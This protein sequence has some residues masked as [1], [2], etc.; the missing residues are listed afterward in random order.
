MCNVDEEGRFG[1]PSR[2]IVLVAAALVEEGVE[3]HVVYPLLDSEVFSRHLQSAGVKCT[4]LNLTRLTKERKILIRYVARFGVE[5]LLLAAFFKKHRFDLVHVNGAYQFK[6]AIAARLSGTP[7]VWHVNDSMMRG[8]VR[9]VFSITARHCASGFIVAGKRVYDHY[10]QGTGLDVRPCLE[11]H[12]PVDT[13]LFRPGGGDN[14]SEER[15][16]VA[17]VTGINPFKGVEFFVMMAARLHER[18]PELRFAVAGQEF[19]TYASYS[20]SIRRLV[21]E[22]RIDDV[23]TFHGL[24]QDVPAFL[25]DADIFVFTSNFE[26]SPMA[27]WEAMA[28]GKPVV[29]TDVGSVREY[30]EDGVSGFVVPVRDVHALSD[31]VSLL[32]R[33]P[34]LRKSLGEA[35]RRVASERLSVRSAAR[36]HRE[37]YA[38]V[39]ALSQTNE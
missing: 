35:A 30:I 36:K 7:V 21:S 26:G 31:R 3:T 33:N 27:V 18:F 22:Q 1:G 9:K 29:T 2:R 10:L 39:A 17:T 38:R 16:T 23:L 37:I 8:L 28:S 6:V 4:P 5:T 11:I 12:A 24:V 32:V 14:P 15:C 19:K 13:E 25:R 20:L 34:G